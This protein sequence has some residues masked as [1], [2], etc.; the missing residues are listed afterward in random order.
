MRR[1]LK[2]H[3]I[4][5]IYNK[6]WRWKDTCYSC[7]HHIGPY[8]T[9]ISCRHCMFWYIASYY[10]MLCG[11]AMCPLHNVCLVFHL[12]FL[13][14]QFTQCSLFSYNTP[15]TVLTC[16]CKPVVLISYDFETR[17]ICHE[18]KFVNSTVWWIPICK[19]VWESASFNNTRKK[20]RR[21]GNPNMLCMEDQRGKRGPMCSIVGRFI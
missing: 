15:W 6:A 17:D 2:I 21:K 12:D 14:F 7:L 20:T 13:V 4:T 3:K 10:F 16:S 9:H 11:C 8:I 18:R 5:E 1:T 19:L